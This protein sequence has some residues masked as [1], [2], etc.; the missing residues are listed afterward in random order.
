MFNLSI[1]LLE[2]I[3]LSHTNLSRFSCLFFASSLLCFI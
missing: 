3:K 2:V 1:L